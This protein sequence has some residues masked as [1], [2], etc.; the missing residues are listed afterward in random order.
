MRSPMMLP[1]VLFAVLPIAAQQASK[2]QPAQV[3]AHR[4]AAN[5]PLQYRFPPD[6][7]ACPVGL[8]VDRRASVVTR[9]VD[10]KTIPTGQGL[11]LHFLKDERRTVV[12]AD[13]TVH[14]FS[15]RVIAQP[16]TAGSTKDLTESFKLVGSGSEPLV[17]KAVWT[18]KMSAIHWVEVTRV[19][20]SDGT[21]WQSSVPNECR[22]EPSLFVLVK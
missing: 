6:R 12:Q 9:Q 5:A 13:I 8:R 3:P 18:E 2:P 21:S 16:L 10:G 14:G 17:E 1:L 4:P 11:T 19:V 15:G 7:M 20:F 22:V